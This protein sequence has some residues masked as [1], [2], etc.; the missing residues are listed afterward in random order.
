MRLER[1]NKILGRLS[2]DLNL[3]SRIK[4]PQTQVPNQIEIP[5]IFNVKSH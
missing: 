1:S 2:D 3:V 5:D 4:Q